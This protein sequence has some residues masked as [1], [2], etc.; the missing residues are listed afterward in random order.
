MFDKS[1][2]KPP[3]ASLESIANQFRLTGWIGFWSQ[4]VLGVVS[5]IVLLLFAVFSQRTGS[6]SNNPG[7][8][9]GI[10]LAVCGL[11]ALGMSVYC[12]FRY[13]RLGRQLRSSNPA[14]RPRKVYTIQVIK[15]A[16][17]VNLVGMLLSLFGAYAIIGTLFA[18]AISPQAIATGIFDPNRIIG[19]LDI[20]AVQA[21]TNTIFAHFLGLSSALWLLNRINRS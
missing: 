4:I 10:F 3:P 16:L 19:G 21:N 18:R 6:P 7:T 1:G 20:L 14:N 12:A 2:T 5:A 9:F 8:G 15:F 17:V 11:I 13:T